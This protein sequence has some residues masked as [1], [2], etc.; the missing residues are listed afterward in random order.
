MF[1]T[2][3]PRKKS[4][5]KKSIFFLHTNFQKLQN[6]FLFDFVLKLLAIKRKNN[7]LTKKIK[8]AREIKRVRKNEV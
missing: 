6:K 2:S 7:C 5:R 8:I 4:S 3:F 1:R